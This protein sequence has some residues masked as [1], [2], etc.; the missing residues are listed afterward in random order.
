MK[1]IKH[2]KS[3]IQ[4]LSVKRDKLKNLSSSS[5]FEHGTEIS[6]HNLLDSVTVRHYLDG[7]EIVLTR[8]PGEEGI[9][10]SRVLEAVLE[11]GFDVVGCTS[12]QKGQRHY[13]TIQ[14]QA[15]NL[16]CIDADRLKGKLI[17]VISLSR[18]E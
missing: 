8:G 1:C 16:N 11:E 9:L 18:Y 6:D 4:D 12:T 7:L 17:D 14:C 3:N 15:S 10:L 2:L 13:T 5:T